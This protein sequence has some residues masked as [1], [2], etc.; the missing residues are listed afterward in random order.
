MSYKLKELFLDITHHATYENVKSQLINW[1]SLVREQN[2][3]KMSV[4]AKTIKIWLE[5]ICNSFIDKRFLNGFI[6]GLNN[7]IKVIK[8]VEFGYKDFDF[9]RLSLLFILNNKNMEKLKK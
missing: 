5:Y 9:F 2:I 6:D 8:R 1:I 7:K 3:E 4:A